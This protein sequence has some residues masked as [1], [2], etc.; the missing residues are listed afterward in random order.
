MIVGNLQFYIVIMV[1]IAL[2]LFF[3]LTL[4]C[5][6][7]N[8]QFTITEYRLKSDKIKKRTTLAVL[9]DLHNY[10]YGVDNEQIIRALDDINPDLVISAGDMVEAGRFV[11]KN[12]QTVG[13][14]A[15]LCERYDFV[16]GCGNHELKVMQAED[17]YP[18]AAKQFAEGMEDARAYLRDRCPQKASSIEPLDN[19]CQDYPER[20]IKIYGMNLEYDYFRKVIVKRTSGKH[21]AELVGEPEDGVYNILIGHNPD[22]M[23]SY[24]QWGADLV[25]SGHVHGGMVALPGHRGIISPRLVLFPKY[26]WGEYHEGRTTMILSGGLGNHT[27][28]VRIFNRA[29]IVKIVL[30]PGSAE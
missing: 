26:H 7:E 14:L 11:K 16:Y 28:H 12:A 8:R 21:V 15:K 3:L 30:E 25:L 27:V 29:E 9:A 19:R 5:R 23:H 6:W 10:E 2:V 24:A 1:F 20:G 22:H 4:Y 18:R 17:E 13:F